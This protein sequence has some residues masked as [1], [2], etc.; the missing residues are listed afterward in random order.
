MNGFIYRLGIRIKEAGERLNI[1]ILKR[2]GLLIKDLVQVLS[3]V[4]RLEYKAIATDLFYIV[5][6]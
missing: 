1:G 2:I 4:A 5:Q 3:S 6:F